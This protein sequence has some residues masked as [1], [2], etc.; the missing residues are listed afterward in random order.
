MRENTT[1]TSATTD[2]LGSW[3]SRE[4]KRYRFTLGT[5][6]YPRYEVNC[7]EGGAIPYA[8]MLKGFGALGD[9]NGGSEI[10]ALSWRGKSSASND[11]YLEIV[12]VLPHA[13]VGA[14][15]ASYAIFTFQGK[16]GMGSG[17]N[18]IGTGD[19]FIV[20]N[21]GSVIINATGVAGADAHTAATGT[22][23]CEAVLSD[24]TALCVLSQGALGGAYA[25][26]AGSL[27]ETAVVSQGYA[28]VASSATD[29]LDNRFMIAQNFENHFENQILQTGVSASG[30][31]PLALSMNCDVATAC[32]VD[33]FVHSDKMLTIG[34]DGLAS[35]SV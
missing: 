30:A 5:T 2:S 4:L 13:Y 11:K 16:H 22:W 32:R 33:T 7:E 18:A 23:V 6:D 12:N 24:N 27:A 20:A 8:E 28:K 19:Q 17:T 29:G 15:N 21:T 35:V 34:A 31:V 25:I 1:V 9:V 14:A 10:D 3:T 26:T